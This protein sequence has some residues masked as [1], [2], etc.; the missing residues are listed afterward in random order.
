MQGVWRHAGK[1]TP[2][3]A[4]ALLELPL[5]HRACRESSVGWGESETGGTDRRA[6][7]SLK[8]GVD[9]RGIHQVWG[10]AFPIIHTV[11]RDNGAQCIVTSANDSKHGPHSL[12]YKG[13]ALDLRTKH[14]RD[15]LTKLSI[16]KKIKEHLGPQF[17]VVYESAGLENEHLHIEFDPKEPENAEPV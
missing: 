3:R 9:L 10:I 12:H 16:I 8:M 11:F 4:V 13:K 7:M 14:V 5:E 1:R 17:D 2:A 6:F 15:E